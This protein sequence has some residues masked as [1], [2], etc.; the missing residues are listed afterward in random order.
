MI[1]SLGLFPK[2]PPPKTLKPFIPSFSTASKP[3]SAIFTYKEFS[4]LLEKATLNFLGKNIKSPVSSI[5]SV[6]ILL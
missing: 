1:A 4:S 3:T 6:T 2:L 5:Y